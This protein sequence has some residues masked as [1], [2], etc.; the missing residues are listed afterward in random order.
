MRLQLHLALPEL[1]FG[2]VRENVHRQ[3]ALVEEVLSRQR[4]IYEVLL[5]LT[6]ILIVRKLLIFCRVGQRAYGAAVLTQAQTR[7]N[8]L[9]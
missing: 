3:A 5:D 7:Q 2:M 1:L 9:R 6:R 8:A 4:A